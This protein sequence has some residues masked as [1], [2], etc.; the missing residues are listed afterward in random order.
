MIQ[1]VHLRPLS[2]PPGP[3]RNSTIYQP[4][5]AWTSIIGGGNYEVPAQVIAGAVRI[6]GNASFSMVR[7]PSPVLT[8]MVALVE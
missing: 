1:W 5:G 3:E 2:C 7:V 4:R 6:Q 8:R